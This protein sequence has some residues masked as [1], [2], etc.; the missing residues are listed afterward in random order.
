MD[1]PRVVVERRPVGPS[2]EELAPLPSRGV[3]GRVARRA[4]LSHQA[5][6]AEQSTL[7]LSCYCS[8]LSNENP[9]AEGQPG[10]SR[11]SPRPHWP[12]PRCPASPRPRSFILKACG[13]QRSLSLEPGPWEEPQSL[14]QGYNTAGPSRLPAT[15]LQLVKPGTGGSRRPTQKPGSRGGLIFCP[16]G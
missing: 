12:S 11:T 3:A 13:E 15:R 10:R 14:H 6:Q 4:G 7:C 2:G 16:Q 5:W 9:Q 8:V 1:G